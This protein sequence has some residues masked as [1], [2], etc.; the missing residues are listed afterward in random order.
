M[1]LYSSISSCSSSSFATCLTVS[2]TPQYLITLLSDIATA[3]VTVTLLANIALAYSSCWHDCSSVMSNRLQPHKCSHLKSYCT[4][5][6][7][8]AQHCARGYAA[9]ARTHQ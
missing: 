3:A 1:Q 6:F 5:I 7:Q 8:A 2:H 9:T 4:V